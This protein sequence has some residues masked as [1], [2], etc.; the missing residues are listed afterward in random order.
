MFLSGGGANLIN[1]EK[2][3]INNGMSETLSFKGLILI[4]NDSINWETFNSG[5]LEPMY[6]IVYGNNIYLMNNH[7]NLYFLL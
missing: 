4:S 1:L 7:Q 2:Y 5:V 6:N 3:F